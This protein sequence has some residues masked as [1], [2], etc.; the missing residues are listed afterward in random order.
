MHCDPGAASAGRNP[1]VKAAPV[2]AIG[3]PHT[4]TANVLH[5]AVA[6][7]RCGHAYSAS[8]LPDASFT[9]DFHCVLIS[10]TTESGSEM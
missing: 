6:D 1:P 5:E 2:N 9:F 3:R 8:G 10:D 4:R 7:D